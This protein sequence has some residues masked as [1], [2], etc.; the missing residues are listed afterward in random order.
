VTWLQRNVS[1]DG[2]E[3]RLDSSSLWRKIAGASPISVL[4]SLTEYFNKWAAA[5]AISKRITLKRR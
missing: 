4:R 1:S 2:V 5:M 3:G